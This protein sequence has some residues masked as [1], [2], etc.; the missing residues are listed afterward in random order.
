MMNYVREQVRSKVSEL[1]KQAKYSNA[2][3]LRTIIVKLMMMCGDE[4]TEEESDYIHNAVKVIHN[5]L[6]EWG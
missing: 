1:L 2:L 6:S 3:G 4:I 5:Y